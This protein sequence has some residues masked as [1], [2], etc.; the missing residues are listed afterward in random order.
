M[1][2]AVAED[3]FPG[4]E[5]AVSEDIAAIP[6]DMAIEGNAEVTEE[7]GFVNGEEVAWEEVPEKEQ[8]AVQESETVEGSQEISEWNAMVQEGTLLEGEEPLPESETVQE[9]ESAPEKKMVFP[10]IEFPA[11][12][13]SNMTVEDAFEEVPQLEKVE[14]GFTAN[15]MERDYNGGNINVTEVLDGEAAFVARA[16]QEN[17]DPNYAY[18]VQNEAVVQGYLTQ[19]N[20]MR[21]Y[22]FIVN[23]PNKISI[24]LEM[25]TS[26]DADVYLF[27]LDQST[28]SLN[29]IVGSVN[30]GAGLMEHYFGILDAGIYYMAVSAYDGSGQFA[31]AF[32]Q[33]QDINNELNDD[34]AN[35]VVFGLGE[36]VTGIID[37]PYDYDFY[38][39]TVDSPMMVRLTYDVGNYSVDYI[40]VD[41]EADMREVS[42]RD[43]GIRRLAAGTYCILVR[44]SNRE[45]DQNKAYSIKVEKVANVADNP[46]STYFTVNEV[47]KIVF[48]S[49][50]NGQNMYVNGN[51]IDISYK[52]FLN[53]SNSYGQ[54]IYDITMINDPSIRAKIF[55]LDMASY[56]LPDT[57]H[58]L[59]GTMGTGEPGGSLLELTV[60][61]AVDFYRI[62]C[63]CT[64]AYKENHLRQDMNMAVVLINPNN[65]KLVDIEEFNYFYDF[66]SGDNEMTFTRPYNI[67]TEHYYAYHDDHYPEEW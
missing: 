54:Q 66:A 39:F 18:V 12:V 59:G 25:A 3:S 26:V 16:A 34:A 5:E 44:S 46:Y 1:D 8:E 35:A 19:T 17:T 10:E 28:Y 49:D 52:Y 24:V 47:A 57:V 21:W 13:D 41:N 51:P 36:T 29:L 53:A 11:E 20:E 67:F 56:T 65:G 50:R 30:S 42:K 9:E 62:N 63:V 45:Y 37:S 23:E 40:R 15:N 61:S 2:S 60:Y 22:G 55:E 64:G 48:Q 33:T 32:Y 58:Y 38:T 27:K 6:E 4:G 7:E 43:E 31:F 14:R